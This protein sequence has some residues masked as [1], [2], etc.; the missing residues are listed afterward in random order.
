[1]IRVVLA[2]D[3]ALVRTGFKVLLTPAPDIEV[4][5]EAANGQQAVECARTTRADVIL[6]DVRMPVMD[7]LEATRQIAAD[8]DLAGVRIVILTTYE[9]D[10]YLIE[11]LRAGASGFLTKD[12]D[13][14]EVLRGAPGRRGRRRAVVTENDPPADQQCEY[15]PAESVH[16]IDRAGRTDLTRTGSRGPGRAR[17]VQ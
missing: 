12:V 7:G 15:R 14:D 9:S 17:P 1:M 5:G 3:Q 2:D 11:A 10:E 6:M 16:A 4:V 8:D 13:T